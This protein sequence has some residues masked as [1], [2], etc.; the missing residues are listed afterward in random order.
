MGINALV[1]MDKLGKARVISDLSLSL[2]S[3]DLLPGKG[4]GKFC[5]M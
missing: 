3:R 5:F 4:A 2:Q 1:E